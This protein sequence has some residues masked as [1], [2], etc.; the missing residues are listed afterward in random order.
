MEQ[1]GQAAE[2]VEDFR[3][4]IQDWLGCSPSSARAVMELQM[5][6][7]PRAERQKI[8]DELHQLRRELAEHAD[9]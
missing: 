9:S 2:T 1:L 8:T 5:R 4:A 7:M 3:S 6:R